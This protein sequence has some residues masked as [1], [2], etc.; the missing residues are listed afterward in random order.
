MSLMKTFFS[1]IF[2]LSFFLCSSQNTI[3]EAETLLKNGEIT[4]AKEILLKRTGGNYPDLKAI[5]LLGDIASFEKDWEKAIENYQKLVNLDPSNASYNFRL[6]GALGFKALNV[7]RFSALLLIPDVKNYL[8]KAAELNRT[9]LR[10]RRALVELY[11]QLPGIL[12]GSEGKSKKYA[13]ELERINPLEGALARAYIQKEKG[14]VPGAVKNYKLAIDQVR[15]PFSD[16]E[17]NNLN[18]E[19]GKISAE[20]NMDSQKGLMF[21][22]AYLKNYNY[23]DIHSPEW[24]YLRKAQ[25]QVH[26]KNKNE[27]LKFVNKALGLN[28][29]FDEA[30]Q[31]KIKISRL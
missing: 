25:I 18:Y 9:H 2:L 1:L 26:L 12:G 10:S 19:I 29:D 14:N 6:G 3:E 22:E 20:Y 8:E 31:E 4:K 23:R 5:Q 11:M 27:A 13:V 28:P 16:P 24:V 15:Q 21:L 7:S 30:K 17:K